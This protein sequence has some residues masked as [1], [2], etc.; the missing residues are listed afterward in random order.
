L[1]ESHSSSDTVDQLPIS[2]RFMT[3]Q[4]SMNYRLYV[5]NQSEL[6]I[7][8]IETVLEKDGLK[9]ADPARKGWP[10]I[11][12]RNVATLSWQP[13]RN[14]MEFVT[15]KWR[16]RM[17][18]KEPPPSHRSIEEIDVAITFTVPGGRRIVHHER[19]MALVDHRNHTMQQWS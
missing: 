13:S 3:L 4:H 9:L 11:E 12:P 14:P 15:I 17:A 6:V 8:P 7:R 18:G 16:E 5:S 19:I 2:I 1:N 10:A